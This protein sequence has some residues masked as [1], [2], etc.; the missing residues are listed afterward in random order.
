M[1]ITSLIPSPSPHTHR[2]RPAARPRDPVRRIRKKTI[3]F[4]LLFLLPAPLTA[5]NDVSM[6]PAAALVSP[7]CKFTGE[8]VT[9]SFGTYDPVSANVARD[10]DAMAKFQLRCVK[11]TSASV[12][13]NEGLYA[14][15]S[16]RRMRGGDGYLNYQMYTDA[17]RSSVWNTS[18][19]VTYSSTTPV[20]KHF[21]IYGRIPAGQDVSA[22]VYMDTVTLSVSF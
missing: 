2:R 10:Q 15:G 6:L 12:S 19:T 4:L 14:A 16:M 9:L 5:A 17:S 22:G 18:N 11:G 1:K 8:N 3:L 13:L 21:S 7:N 20:P